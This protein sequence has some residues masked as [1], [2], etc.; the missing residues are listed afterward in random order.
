[1]K[2]ETSPYPRFSDPIARIHWKTGRKF[3]ELINYDQGYESE[4]QYLY[5]KCDYLLSYGSSEEKGNGWE[6]NFVIM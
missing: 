1:M 2:N 5:G 4:W 3:K 6:T